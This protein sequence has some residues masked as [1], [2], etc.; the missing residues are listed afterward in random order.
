M[1]KK[2]WNDEYG[3]I[4][5]SEIATVGSVL[6]IGSVAGLAQL[7]DSVANE[8][9]ETGAAIQGLNQSYSVQGIST[10][11]AQVSGSGFTDTNQNNNGV[12]AQ[13]QAQNATISQGNS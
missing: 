7:R 6:V 3:A 4:I 1:W 12:N 11:S 10:P 5:S 9:I 2:F 8:L 13:P